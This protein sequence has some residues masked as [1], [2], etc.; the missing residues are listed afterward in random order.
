[1]SR[2]AAGIAFDLDG[3]FWRVPN[4]FPW[5]RATVMKCIDRK[6]PFVFLTNSMM[7]PASLKE[8]A[9]S[10]TLYLIINQVEETRKPRK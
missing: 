7:L 2:A 5:S 1:M 3:V 6:I 10:I 9:E 8:D 4:V